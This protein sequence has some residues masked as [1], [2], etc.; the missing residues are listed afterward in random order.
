MPRACA[1]LSSRKRGLRLRDGQA[2]GDGD[3]RAEKRL[4]VKP[5]TAASRAAGLAGT[6]TRNSLERL[7]GPPP[8][9]GEEPALCSP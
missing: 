3:E 7:S 9:G 6:V 2:P 1:A 5:S 4:H 8:A